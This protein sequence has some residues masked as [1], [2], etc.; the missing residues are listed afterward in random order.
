M[1]KLLQTRVVNYRELCSKELIND[2]KEAA[3][4]EVR[5]VCRLPCNRCPSAVENINAKRVNIKGLNSYS[6]KLEKV[7]N[8]QLLIVI[9]APNLDNWLLRNNLLFTTRRT[10]TRRESKSSK[11]RLSIVPPLQEINL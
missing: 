3:T 11:T 4:C 10:I 9:T 2:L 6:I 8:E 5:T 7:E 1:V